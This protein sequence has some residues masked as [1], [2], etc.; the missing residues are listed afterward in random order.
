MYIEHWKENKMKREEWCDIAKGILTFLVVLGH[1]IQN[2][3]IPTLGMGYVYIIIYS[4]HM[5]AFFIISGYLFKN[6]KEGRLNFIKRKAKK[7]I[8]PAFCFLPFVIIYKEIRGMDIQ[9]NYSEIVKT[10]LNIRGGVYSNLWFFGALFVA[11]VIIYM[12]MSYTEKESVLLTLGT[13]CLMLSMVW[14]RIIGVGLP[15]FFEEGIL[16]IPF[17][18]IGIE[19][20]KCPKVN[21]TSRVSM[22]ILM[23]ANILC[24]GYKVFIDDTVVSFL[25]LSYGNI[26]S[27][28]IIALVF[29]FM[30]F[31]ICKLIKKAEIGEIFSRIGKKSMWIYGIHWIFIA[32]MER[33][34]EYSFN[35]IPIVLGNVLILFAAIIST[36][37]SYVFAELIHKV[38]YIIKSKRYEL[39]STIK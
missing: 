16:A 18:I 21:R 27:F 24:I 4:F 28:V 34:L 22:M 33:I 32:V 36:V 20:K 5:P 30:L 25:E 8:I 31:D 9:L 37:L 23:F 1:C 7:L 13:V 38:Y 12:V 10:I 14:N 2:I 3:E 39:R 19:L 17:M 6:R 29:S 26:I 11:S 35:N 15:L